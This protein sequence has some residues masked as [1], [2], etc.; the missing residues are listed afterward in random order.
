ML[1]SDI[2]VA[3]ADTRFSQLEVKRGLVAFGGAP[4]RM[5]QSAGWGN[6]MRYLLTGDEFDAEP[7]LRF[8]WIQEIVPP[9]E[10]KTR[11]IA[12]ARSIAAQAPLAVKATID[13][14]R[15]SVEQGPLATV[16]SDRARVDA[17]IK[18]QDFAEGV[19]SFKERREPAYQGK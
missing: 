5:V 1:A 8:G 6:A 9:G 14:S 15:M 17:L 10:H 4:I 11:A 16:E 19:A 7:A 13:A 2:T 3:A 12:L 18:S